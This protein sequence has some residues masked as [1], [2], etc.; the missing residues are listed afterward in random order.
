MKRGKINA[1][2]VALLVLGC[3]SITGTGSSHLTVTT[4]K[5][6]Y[7][8][9][10]LSGDAACRTYGFT[11]I[12]RI[13]NVGPRAVYFGVCS[14]RSRATLFGISMADAGSSSESAYNPVWACVGVGSQ[15]EFRPGSVRV[16][17][18]RILGPTSVSHLGGIRGALTGR[19]RIG[20]AVQGCQGDGACRLNAAAVSNPFEVVLAKQ[21]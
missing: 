7:E 15:P 5:S 19:M 1:C 8:A 18:V 9:Q 21:D 12:A 14:P 4:D 17:T 13:E 6:V 10:C 3:A 16:D 11:L 2:G 20:F